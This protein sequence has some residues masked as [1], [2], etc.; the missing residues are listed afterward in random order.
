M[1]NKIVSATE[2]AAMIRTGDTVSISG[3]V[4]IGT[5]DE[6]LLGLERRFLDGGSR[7]TTGKPMPSSTM[8]PFPARSAC[9]WIAWRRCRSMSAR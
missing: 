1:K 3:F 7:R 8:A 4:G 2:A 9:R 5:P 6:L